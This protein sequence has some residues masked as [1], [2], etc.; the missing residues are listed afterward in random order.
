MAGQ[1][2]K[3]G[4][5]PQVVN[6]ATLATMTVVTGH[7]IPRR[8]GKPVTFISTTTSTSGAP[9]GTMTFAEGSTVWASNVPVDGAATRIFQHCGT[10]G[11]KSHDHGP[12]YRQQRMVDQ[13]WEHHP[14]GEQNRNRHH[15]EFVREP[16]GV[17]PASHL[18]A[19]VTVSAGGNP[20][21]T[22]TFQ[23][24]GTIFGT[25]T[26][27]GN[28]RAGL[29][30]SSLAAGSHILTATY[31]GDSNFSVSGSTALGQTVNS[32]GTTTTLVSS[33]NPSAHNQAITLTATAVAN[34]PG[35]AAPTGTITFKDGSRTLT[36]VPLNAGSAS[37]TISNLNKGTHSITA[38]YGGGPGFLISRSQALNQRVQ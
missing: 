12:L 17:Q 24:G 3:D 27:D 30:I 19:V 15:A 35:A 32:D 6:P 21:G 2:R 38:A 9:T 13:Q 31:S 37:L 34:A 22:V 36:S 33:L 28:G 7:P 25:G 10:G 5:S 1:Q 26:L 20:T 23:D 14:G 4:G 29:I 16:V 11:R 18:A 8:S